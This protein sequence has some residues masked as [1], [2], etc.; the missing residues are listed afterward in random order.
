M[1]TALKR[2]AEPITTG[3]SIE[4]Q[5][6]A[7]CDAPSGTHAIP[8]LDGTL[9][10]SA[11]LCQRL[12]PRTEGKSGLPAMAARPIELRLRGTIAPLPQGSS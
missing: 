6:T 2:N 11:L 4:R 10:A 3:N 7:P 12:Q 5:K 9:G 8:I 1:R